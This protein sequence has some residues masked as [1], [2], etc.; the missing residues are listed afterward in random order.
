AFESIGK[1]LAAAG[2]DFDDVVDIMSFHIG[3]QSH[4]Q[5]FMKIKD[6]YIKAPYPSWTAVGTTELA[7][8]GALVE[9][10]IIAKIPD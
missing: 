9:I 5:D 4:M 7:V 2:A 8:P 1:T 10:R 6:K 3:L